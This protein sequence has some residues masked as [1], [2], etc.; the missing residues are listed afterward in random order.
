MPIKH[1]KQHK[2]ISHMKYTYFIKADNL[3]FAFSNEQ[4]AEKYYQKFKSLGFS[5][6]KYSIELY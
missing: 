1:N 3:F 4:K 2:N 6:F 5:V